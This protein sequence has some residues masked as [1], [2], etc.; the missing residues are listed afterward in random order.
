METESAGHPKHPPEDRVLKETA[1]AIGGAAGKLAV[2]ARSVI[3][4]HQAATPAPPKKRAGKLPP[5][6]KSRLPRKQKK[7]LAARKSA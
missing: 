5:K 7:M 2:L 3:P 4:H 1:K 6:N